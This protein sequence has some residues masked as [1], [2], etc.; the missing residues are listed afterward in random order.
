[1]FTKRFCLLVVLFGMTVITFQ[2]MSDADIKQTDDT[3][4]ASGVSGASPYIEKKEYCYP[5]SRG[6]RY[7]Y[8]V[9]MTG[10][11]VGTAELVY[12]GLSQLEG[13]DVVVITLTTKITNFFDE[14]RIFADA[15]TFLPVRIE[16][17]IRRLGLSENIVEEYSQDENTVTIIKN[18]GKRQT[19]QV[20]T[21]DAPLQNIISLIYLLRSDAIFASDDIIEVNLPLKKVQFSLAGSKQVAVP[22]GKYQ[23]QVIQSV[24]RKYTIWLSDDEYKTPLRID[25]AV[26]FAKTNMMLVEQYRGKEQGEGDGR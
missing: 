20:I 4:I 16:R 10:L 12:E 3:S 22:E 1:M 24:P 21:S 25:G 13:R 19:Q 7:V 14:E 15:E 5:F 26:G 2:Y 23:A 18:E 17:T 8:A 6:E 11:R 9:K